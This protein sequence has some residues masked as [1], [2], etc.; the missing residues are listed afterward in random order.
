MMPWRLAY[1]PVTMDAQ[2]GEQS[3]VVWNALRHIA[4]SRASR[5]TWGVRPELVEAQVVD[6]DDEKVRTLDAGERRHSGSLAWP[7]RS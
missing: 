3:G 4:P 2:L 6:E 7:V 1:W 5:S